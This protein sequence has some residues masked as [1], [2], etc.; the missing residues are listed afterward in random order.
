MRPVSTV[1][2]VAIAAAA[3]SAA[4]EVRG[5]TVAETP[6]AA[7]TSAGEYISWREH[8]IDDR[9]V[10]AEP[11]LAGADGLQL[12]DLDGD[13][14]EDIVSVHEADI[15]YDDQPF[16]LVRIAWGSEDPTSWE[17]STLASGS[18]VAG[19][20]DVSIAD[21]NGDGHPDVVV[22]AE[23]AHLIYFQ[24]PGKDSRDRPWERVIPPITTGRGS[25]IR[26]F[27]ADLDDDGRPEIVAAN[28]GDQNAGVDGK[29]VVVR[30]SVS[31]FTLPPDPLDATLWREQVLG[32]GLAPINSEPVDLDGDGDLDVVGGFRV[33]ERIAWYENLGDL[34]FREHDIDVEWNG[35]PVALQGFN[36]DYADL[37]GDG[38]TDIVEAT[39]RLGPLI[40]LR[41][42]GDPGDSWTGHAIG[43]FVPDVVVSVRLA[44]IDG[45]GDLDAFSG[46]YSLGPRDRDGE[47]IGPEGQLGRIGWFENRGS[48]PPPLWQRHDVVRRKRGMY[49]QWV[50]RDLDGDGDLDMVGTR[51]N[52][53]PYDGVFWLEQVRTPRPRAAFEA[54]RD[55]DS[56]DMPLPPS[57]LDVPET[58]NPA[59]VLPVREPKEPTGK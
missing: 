26:V 46:T 5:S 2:L 7:T 52:S 59:E 14:F 17:L 4:G 48:G 41:Q 10:G 20:E 27:F 8:I 51:G 37:D 47:T 42:P 1:V 12:A 22:A 58:L 3:E 43:S 50:A 18:D 28:K 35:E 19:A 11:A 24:N 53:F 54:A 39:P 36:M 34:E 21:A 44:D 56:Q 23:K 38:R 13:G 9:D 55:I 57:E 15:V 45:D 16:G 40:W 49:D 30:T 25:Y 6:T 29:P 31:F 33:D 32:K